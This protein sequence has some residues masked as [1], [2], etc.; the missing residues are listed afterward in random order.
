MYEHGNKNIKRM[1]KQYTIYLMI[2]S[3][4]ISTGS[5]KTGPVKVA[6]WNVENLFDIIDDPK[7]N[8]E[9]YLIGG[10]KNVTNETYNLKFQ[11][12]SKVINQIMPDI[13]GLCEVENRFVLNE[14]NEYL[15]INYKIV[16]YESPDQRGIDVGL[17]YNP[18]RV[19]IVESSPIEVILSSGK[20][21]RDILYVHCKK[22]DISL[23]LYVNH[24]PSKYGGVK[25]TIPSRAKAAMTLRQHIVSLLKQDGDA[26]IVVMG[27]LNDEPHEPSVLKHL[28]A[29]L[30]SS[31]VHGDE[32]ILWNLMGPWHK[33]PQGSTYVY[34]GE[35]MVYDHLI[36]SMGLVDNKGLKLVNKSVGVFDGKE[37]RQHGGKYNGYPFR[38]WAGNRILGGYSDH[39]PIYL[40]IE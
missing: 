32:N 14:L 3:C 15:K 10:R 33:N 27:D 24:W 6:F 7:T 5:S 16:H 2:I 12:I 19:Y 17:L 18:N 25:K 38:F 11:N 8:D 1:K 21:T 40:S 37:Y 29:G 30:D 31:S 36:I 13:L 4:F 39:M 35:H 9:D 20:P 26:E 34:A 22:D 23:H 28:G